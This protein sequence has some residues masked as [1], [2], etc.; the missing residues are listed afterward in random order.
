MSALSIQPT[1]PTFADVNGQPLDNGYIWLG[2]ANLDPQT[3]PIA[4]YWDAA[5]TMPAAQP[6]RTLAGYPSNNGTPARIYVNSDYS[7]RVMNKSG[8]TVYSAP[9]ATERYSDVVIGEIDFLQ[10]GANAVVRTSQNKM[11]DFISVKDFGAVG[12]GVTDDFTAITNTITYAATIRATVYFPAGVYLVSSTVNVPAGVRLS[13]DGQGSSVLGTPANG[14]QILYLGTG[15]AVSL[16]GPLS[17]VEYLTVRGS[18]TAVGATGILVNGDANLVESWFLNYV[19]I[20]NF[21]FGTA[22][23]LKGIN[24]GAVTYG[25]VESLR[26]RNAKTGIKIEDTG[27][28]AGFC[29]TNQF[30]GGAINGGGFDYA[31]YVNGGNDN[32][33]YGMSI[34]PPTSVY[35]HIYINKGQLLFYGRIEAN[36]TTQ[37]VPTVFVSSLGIL[38]MND[39]LYGGTLIQDNSI[40]SIIDVKSSKVSNSRPLKANT[41]KNASFSNTEPSTLTIQDWTLTYTGSAPTVSLTAPEV[42]DNL[43]VLRVDVPVGGAVL[44][45]PTATTTYTSSVEFGAFIKTSFAGALSYIA[46]PGVAS[47]SP[48]PADNLWHSIGMSRDVS[49]T[50]TYRI[51]LTNSSASVATYYITAPF[52]YKGFSNTPFINSNGGILTG[53][54]EGGAGTILLPAAGDNAYY[55][56][57]TAE[58]TIPKWGNVIHIGGTARTITR[59]NNLAANRIQPG[60]VIRLVFDIGGVGV[61]DGSP[62]FIDLTAAF[63][64]SAPAT[65][66]ARS[67]LLLEALSGGVWYEL[68]RK[69]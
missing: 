66:S 26:I 55:T 67:W 12:D 15:T 13:G 68:D 60:T 30:Y 16:N 31:I 37:A 63:T 22:L 65:P 35:G 62:G 27:G 24:S 1:Y 14:S 52:L 48:H 59:L 20:H 54:L 17:G 58:L 2:A 45:G 10:A 44:L 28:A 51:Q 9:M 19:T 6:I 23:Y 5:L 7:I 56:S 21:V 25:A 57:A 11:R 50:A 39:T 43:P 33:F 47:S 49:S 8:S 29:N 38:Y 36:T 61:T 40:S 4:V 41:L 53:T 64:S 18:P 42:V 34:E 3:N 32:R 69:V 46:S